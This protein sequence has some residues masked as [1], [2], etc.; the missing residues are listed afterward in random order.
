MDLFFY[1]YIYWH[2]IFTISEFF[3]KKMFMYTWINLFIGWYNIGHC[4]SK[5]RSISCDEDRTKGGGKGEIRTRKKECALNVCAYYSLIII[6][7]EKKLYSSMLN[8]QSVS[9]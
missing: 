9:L 7:R 5:S 3:K 1:I 4:N 2:I 8:I 6:F